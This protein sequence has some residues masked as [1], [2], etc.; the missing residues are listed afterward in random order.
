MKFLKYGFLA[1]A[2]AVSLMACSDD[3][4]DDDSIA[5]VDDDVAVESSSASTD[6]D[7]GTTSSG[8]TSSGSTSSAS[9]EASSDDAECTAIEKDTLAL[10]TYVGTLSTT[11]NFETGGTDDPHV[12]LTLDD[13]G[14]AYLEAGDDV[15]I[16]EED[17]PSSIYEPSCLEEFTTAYNSSSTKVELT[18][19]VYLILKIGDS[20]YPLYVSKVK[21]LSETQVTAEF[22]WWKVSE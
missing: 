19:G 11:Y 22:N 21:S 9:E 13:D 6:T 1:A 4:D 5:G 3:D 7:S 15:V 12:T 8:S 2:L 18:T 10:S 17:D 16:W 20:T 14:V